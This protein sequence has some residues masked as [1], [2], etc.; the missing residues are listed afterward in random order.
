MQDLTTTDLEL[1]SGG[2]ACAMAA[3]IASGLMM[4]APFT[5]GITGVGAFVVLGGMLLGG[6]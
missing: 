4:A 1:V 2:N 5:E 3:G 6:C